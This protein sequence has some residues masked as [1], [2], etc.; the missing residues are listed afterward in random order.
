[1]TME[2]LS[3]DNQPGFHE[4]N[5]GELG[6]A[7]GCDALHNE[8]LESITKGGVGASV[9]HGHD[10]SSSERGGRD[11]DPGFHRGDGAGR[12]HDPGFHRGDGAGRDHDPGFHR[13]DGAGRDHDPGFI[14]IGNSRDVHHLRQPGAK[15]EIVV[16]IPPG[17]NEEIILKPLPGGGEEIEIEPLPGFRH[18]PSTRPEIDRLPVPGETTIT[19]APLPG[20]DHKALKRVL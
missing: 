20:F 2:L 16:R 15:T 19:I 11:H 17:A 12:D 18:L 9:A 7:A 8:F 4:K 5:V 13:G 14:H 3:S 1:M 10:G 6:K